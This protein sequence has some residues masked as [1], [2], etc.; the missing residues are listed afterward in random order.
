VELLVAETMG[1]LVATGGRILRSTMDAYQSVIAETA[2]QVLTGT[3]TRRQAAQEALN[4]FA[5][6]GITGF[7]DKSGRGWNLHSYTEMAMR[8]GTAKAAVKG[9][10]DRL[11]EHGLD[12]MIISD[13]PRECPL[14]R[15][16]EGRVVSISGASAD[17]PSMD[18]ARNAGLFHA[19]CRHSASLYLEGIT[20]PYGVTAD[21]AGYEAGQK[22]RYLERKVREN[23]RV[24]AAALD[25]AA[26]AKAQAKIRAY[27]AK[28]REHVAANELKR[29]PYREQVGKA[30]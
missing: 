22:Q 3:Q 11:Q 18:M 13:A 21:P 5:A 7:V 4:R 24:K 1:Y 19:N 8:T 14:C 26:A 16:W 30:I 20:R 9:H 25:D 23:K 29:L 2:A 6:K 10:T 28:L 27:Q 17:Y 12:L 15:P